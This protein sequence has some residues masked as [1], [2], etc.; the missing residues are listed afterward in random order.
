MCNEN[1]YPEIIRSQEDKWEEMRYV[2]GLLIDPNNFLT[3]SQVNL[4]F[5]NVFLC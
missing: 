2:Q 1:A 5:L 3:D 4:F